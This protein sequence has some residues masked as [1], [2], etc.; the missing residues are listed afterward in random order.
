MAGARSPWNMD[1]FGE[2]NESHMKE[3]DVIAHDFD[4]DECQRNC[5]FKYGLSLYGDL[6]FPMFGAASDD[7]ARIGYFNCVLK[8]NR[9][10]W[11][12]FDKEMERIEKEA[13]D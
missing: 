7:A 3:S 8:C 13:D 10:H 4:L 6:Y 1:V 9:K 2:L 12:H 11:K 5:R